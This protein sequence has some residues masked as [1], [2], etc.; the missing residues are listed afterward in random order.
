M[1]QGPGGRGQDLELRARARGQQPGD[2]AQGPE[3]KDQGK[4]VVW[5]ELAWLISV[6]LGTL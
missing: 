4:E 5:E 6:I 1:G 2:K 3:G